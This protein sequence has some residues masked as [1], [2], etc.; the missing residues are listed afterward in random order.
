[1]NR[2]IKSIPI[3]SDSVIHGLV[4][5]AIG[6]VLGA[7][8]SNALQD[9]LTIVGGVGFVAALAVLAGFIFAWQNME[10]GRHAALVA[11]EELASDNRARAEA[12]EAS[13][14]REL[15]AHQLA[16]GDSAN[17]HDVVVAAALEGAG[18]QLAELKRHIKNLHLADRLDVKVSI[19]S[20]LRDG[21]QSG[22]DFIS[23]AM[24]NPRKSLYILDLIG[25]DGYPAD[26]VLGDDLREDHFAGL[27]QLLSDRP[28]VVYRRICQMA[29]PSRR[30]DLYVDEA[31]GSHIDL[32]LEVSARRTSLVGVYVAPILYPYKFSI[33][34]DDTLVLQ[35]QRIDPN[36]SLALDC[37]VLIRDA[38][39]TLV[40]V[41][42]GMWDDVVA[43]HDS[44]K[45]Q[46][47]PD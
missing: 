45:L 37:E 25:D 43:M 7:L 19:A 36:G 3:L 12:L 23:L 34:D 40:N 41:F 6:A 2:K 21:R 42:R 30:E 17:R 32:M 47:T 33:I 5:A 14:V 38:E 35:L 44:R 24:A 1:M 13:L 8:A 4:L 18:E 15:A 22:P 16:L 26:S 39:G 9:G 20:D 28:E 10:Q 11:L 46:A 31:F 27:N 29:D